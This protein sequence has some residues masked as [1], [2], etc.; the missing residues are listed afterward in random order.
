MVVLFTF[1]GINK[2]EKQAQEVH[3]LFVTSSKTMAT[4]TR[5]TSLTLCK[6]PFL[7]DHS[8]DGDKL[9]TIHCDLQE[10][11]PLA[12]LRA[13]YCLC[14]LSY[15]RKDIFS[16]EDNS[17]SPKMS[18][19][20]GSSESLSSQGS[21][22]SNRSPRFSPVSPKPGTTN[23]KNLV[24]KDL[25]S[26]FSQ[27]TLNVE[28]IKLPMIDNKV[29]NLSMQELVQVA[30]C[31]IWDVQVEKQKVQESLIQIRNSVARMIAGHKEVQPS[32]SESNHSSSKISKEAFTESKNKFTTASNS[33]R[34]HPSGEYLPMSKSGQNAKSKRK[35]HE[36]ILLIPDQEVMSEAVP[37][38]SMI[39]G[40]TVVEEE[41]I[42][43]VDADMD[44]P[45]RNVNNV[46]EDRDT[47]ENEANSLNSSSNVIKQDYHGKN[48][49]DDV[50]I[51]KE[52]KVYSSSIGEVCKANKTDQEKR[53]QRVIKRDDCNE[54][55]GKD[56]GDLKKH[57][58]KDENSE[59]NKAY[60]NLPDDW[61]ELP[62][63]TK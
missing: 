17:K 61:F 59:L 25:T 58:D 49:T 34:R 29:M 21:K 37:M 24:G 4:T 43:E 12:C 27:G 56:S 6:N 22:K 44:D 46:D 55:C 63:D 38:L 35:P 31:L 2:Y 52:K 3:A 14:V 48:D 47:A 54:T 15:W 42:R 1:L 30:Q 40:T 19:L 11:T 20:S 13:Y 60:N 53:L 28:G 62:I 41:D 23:K 9:P 33:L 36:D 45:D 10:F 5:K 16:T 39:K 32:N 51:D 8:G 18:Q 26:E 7:L 57:G 50:D